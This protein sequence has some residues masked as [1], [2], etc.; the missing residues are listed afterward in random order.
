MVFWIQTD[1]NN[2][3]IFDFQYELIDVLKQQSWLKNDPTPTHLLVPD[4]EYALN[5][6]NN[7]IDDIEKHKRDIIPVGSIEFVNSFLDKYFGSRVQAFNVPASIAGNERYTKRLYYKNLAPNDALHYINEFKLM[8]FLIKDA[9]FPKG[10]MEV[11]RFGN[12]NSYNW[13]RSA[14]PNERFDMSLLLE[15]EREIVSEYRAFVSGNVVWD[16]RKYLGDWW[17]NDKLN[18]NFVIEVAKKLSEDKSL[19]N[20]KT[21]DFAI[22]KN[23]ETCVIEVHSFISC[24]TYGF[25]GNVLPKMVKRAYLW[26]ADNPPKCNPD[27]NNVE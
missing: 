19:P 4:A 6:I 1:E 2:V 24:G 17:E 5:V 21:I 18:K 14:N 7:S 9:R 26:Q 25:S 15:G 16:V 8:A 12:E 11:C 10:K 3:P 23:G 13:L 20:D 27:G 22:L